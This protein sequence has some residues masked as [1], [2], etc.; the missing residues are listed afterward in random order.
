MIRRHRGLSLD[1]VAGLAG[2]SKPYLSQLERGQRG[3]NRRGLLENLAGALGCSVADL[4]GQPYLAADRATADALAVVEGRRRPTGEDVRAAE[5]LGMTHLLAAQL[6]G[7]EGRAG[8]ADT[9]LAEAA[10]L[11]AATGER[12]TLTRLQTGGRG[13]PVTMSTATCRIGQ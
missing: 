8:E 9:H 11:A 1:V 7:R 4:T 3:I 10:S 2:I 13:S 5:A 6:A 12:N